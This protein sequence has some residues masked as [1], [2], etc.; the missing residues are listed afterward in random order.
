MAFSVSDGFD[1]WSAPRLITLTNVRPEVQYVY[2]NYFSVSVPPVGGLV[3]GDRFGDDKWVTVV[4]KNFVNSTEL[5][6]R[7]GG[8]QEDLA[9]EAREVRFNHEGMVMCLVDN[10]KLHSLYVNPARGDMNK[11]TEAL[12]ERKAA[13]NIPVTEAAS[14]LQMGQSTVVGVEA[15]AD[16]AAPEQQDQDREPQ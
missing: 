1:V 2:P 3:R 14:T 9:F 11:T 6:C 16:P 12:R 15:G 5:R 4:G 8:E 7:F 13:Y 10:A